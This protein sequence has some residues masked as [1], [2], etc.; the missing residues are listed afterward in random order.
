MHSHR[1]TTLT[2]AK[3]MARALAAALRAR[4]I[5]LSHGESLDLVARQFGCP[6]WNI[7]SARLR[8][9]APE[10]VRSRPAPKAWDFLAEHPAE[11]EHGVER[12]TGGNVALIRHA[13]APAATGYRD[14][15][16]IFGCYLQTVSAV[17]FHGRRL[18]LEAS[19]RTAGITHGATIW[20]RVDAR[21]GAALA[22]DNLRGA[23][24]GWLFGDRDWTRRRIVI[25]VAPE[26]VSLSFGFF[27]KG[28][29]ALRARGLAL[30]E[31]D[32]ATPLTAE[33]CPGAGAAPGWRAPEN[34]DFAALAGGPPR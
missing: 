1:P 27:A 8:R 20:A 22:F 11:F 14:P 10:P 33:P 16:A 15:A 19:L 12:G 32:P 29:G 26:A 3:R 13:V 30:A 5:A 6:D 17:P 34:L 21:P 7:L 25:A 23:E 2:D 24:A 31:A 9:G 4:D 18:V 28:T